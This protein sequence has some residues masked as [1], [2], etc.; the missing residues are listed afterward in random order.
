L[1][2][3]ILPRPAKPAGTV[4]RTF[5]RIWV[6]DK[7]IPTR[8]EDFWWRL[9]DLNPGCEFVTWRDPIE[10]TDYELGH[11]FSSCR[12][13]A[14]LADLLR[15]EIVHKFGGIYIDVDIEPL[16]TF[17]P[18]FSYE[19]FVVGCWLFG[20]VP[21][22]P[23]T[24]ALINKILEYGEELP[25][26]L[27]SDVTGPT[28]WNSTV[29][30]GFPGVTHLPWVLFSPWNWG[31][32]PDWNRVTAET[33]AVNHRFATWVKL[34]QRVAYRVGRTIRGGLHPLSWT[35][36]T[37]WNAPSRR[38]THSGSSGRRR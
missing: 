20:G 3:E 13:P 15:I 8:A 25:R 14:Q 31:E 16:R 18:L 4:P 10:P 2:T 9:K 34:H 26:G 28:V 22:H 29:S 12:H 1:G 6:G 32:R 33:Y 38:G 17:R 23:A 7:P 36:R 5:H 35:T 30:F 24:R 37:K 11:L 27:I 21:G 19:F